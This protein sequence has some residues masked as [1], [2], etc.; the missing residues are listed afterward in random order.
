MVKPP[1][2]W[3]FICIELEIDGRVI[4]SVTASKYTFDSLYISLLR[5]GQ[6]QRLPWA[7]FISMSSYQKHR[8]VDVNDRYHRDKKGRF[9]KPNQSSFA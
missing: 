6:T 7:I 4:E 2:R 3:K 1:S 5:D 8:E 9:A